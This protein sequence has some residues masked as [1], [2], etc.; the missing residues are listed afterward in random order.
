MTLDDIKSF[1]EAVSAGLIGALLSIPLT[2]DV[3][4]A[5]DRIIL[6]ASG[7]ATAYYSAPLIIEYL[8]VKPSL[9]SS[10]SFLIGVFGMS[11]VAAV[12]RSARDADIWGL[13]RSRFG[14]P[15]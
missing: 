8:H 13:I 3:K 10:I 7:T 6:V 14:G 5:K 12:L 15:A 1:A 9:G 4:A 2:P 11:V